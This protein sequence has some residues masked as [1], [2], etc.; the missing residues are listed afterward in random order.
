MSVLY[1]CVQKFEEKCVKRDK[2]KKIYIYISYLRII[3]FIVERIS[4]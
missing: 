1:M 4:R 2:I 3:E